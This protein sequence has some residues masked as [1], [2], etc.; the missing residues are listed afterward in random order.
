MI[1]IL[2][3]ALGILISPLLTVWLKR[4]AARGKESPSRMRERFGYAGLPRP[5]G[6]L[7]WLHAA[8]VGEVQ[9]V[10][11]M[12]RRLL[13]RHPHVHLLI[14]S[15]TVT[16]AH[17]LSQHA[18][19]RTLHQFIPVDTYPAVNRFLEYWQPDL[20]LWVESE[21]WPQLLWQIQAHGIPALLVNA[22]ISRQTA[23]NWQHW[24]RMISSLLSTFDGIYAGS[25]E[26]AKRLRDLGAVHVEEAGNLKYDAEELPA[27][28]RLLDALQ[29]SLGNRPVWLAASTHAGEEERIISVHVSMLSLMPDLLTILVPRHAARGDSIAEI[30]QQRNIDFVRRSNSQ[31]PTSTTGIYLADTM[32]E[33]GLFYRACPIAFLGGSLIPHGGHNPLE[34]ARLNCAILSGPHVHNFSGIMAQ[35]REEDALTIVHNEQELQEAVTQLLCNPPVREA[36]TARAYAYVASM[37]GAAERIL[38]HID[39]LLEGA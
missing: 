7:I 9:S 15:G 8:S 39:R 11:V 28:P 34:P 33:L 16:S 26:D 1:R 25:E 19:P 37:H 10:L 14:T 5:Q 24:P 30:L 21:L 2:Y 17:M 12:A 23:R 29:N 35:M 36:R 38:Q 3:S 31:L 27:N 22:R 20:A 6:A 4:R 32:G 18:L 13:D